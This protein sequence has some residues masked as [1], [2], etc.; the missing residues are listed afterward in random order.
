[1]NLFRHVENPGTHLRSKLG[2]MRDD[3]VEF[4]LT[5]GLKA[6]V[7]RERMGEF[8]M[9]V[10][11][12]CY[13]KGFRRHAFAELSSPVVV[14]VG[15][16]LGFFCLYM[17]SVLRGASV[18]CVE[19]VKA[20]YDFLVENLR[21]NGIENQV[22]SVQAALCA[23][24]GTVTLVDPADEAFPTG[25]SVLSSPGEGTGYEVAALS[26]DDFLKQRDLA[27]VSLLKLDCEGA[28]YDILYHSSEASLKAIQNVAAEIHVGKGDRENVDA[29]SSFL[30]QAGFACCVSKD[31]HFVWACRDPKNLVQRTL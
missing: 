5:G 6:R 24:T 14:D 2:L 29:F 1:V 25:A 9:V 11:D 21:A 28:E 17:L 22:T 3:P 26:L 16:N 4:T 8:K 7:P 15:A 18:F 10:L 12:D 13:L 19:P 23:K 27:Q 30:S 31:R 20:N